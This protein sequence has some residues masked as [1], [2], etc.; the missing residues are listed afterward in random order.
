GPLVSQPERSV[1]VTSA[2]SSSPI[3]GGWNPSMVSRLDSDE[4]F[5]ID[6]EPNHR[7]RAVGVFQRLLAAVADGE[8]RAGAVA[9]PPEL[10]EV[11]AGSPVDAD[12]ADALQREGL[13][14]AGDLAQFA[15]RRHQKAHAG[16]ADP[17]DRG[18]APRGNVLAESGG[19]G[20][21]VQVDPQR[22]T[23]ELGVVAAAQP[24][25]QL[26][27]AGPVRADQH[28]RVARPVLDPDSM[29]GDGRGLDDRADLGGL[30]LAR[31]RVREC[32]AER[33]QRRRQAGGHPERVAVAP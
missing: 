14:Q 12:A 7:L 19:K 6:L 27:D 31:P 4:S 10:A 9:P 5:D 20:G 25:R 17:R 32:N 2:I 29:G 8:D 13:L 33:G 11:V 1:S 30:E 26:A 24:C 28:L 16:T 23:A 22:D 21:A 3:A 18:E 15:R